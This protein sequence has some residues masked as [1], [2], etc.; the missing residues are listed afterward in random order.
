MGED[1]LRQ[2]MNASHAPPDPNINVLWRETERE[3][4]VLEY[5]SS[6]PH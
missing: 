2:N 4:W 5:L 6:N 1:Q 3:G